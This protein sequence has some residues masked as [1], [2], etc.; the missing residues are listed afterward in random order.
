MK[1]NKGQAL[2]EFILIIPVFVFILLTIIDVSNI[3]ISKSKLENKLD[4]IVELYKNND[5]SLSEFITKNNLNVTYE[6]KDKYTDIL[7]KS[8]V[9]IKTPGL[10]NILGKRM[11][12]ETSRTIY[13]E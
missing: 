9:N 5:N 4:T 6:Q 10:N 1:G 12:I 11:T 13:N 8:S 7:V 2:V 3:V